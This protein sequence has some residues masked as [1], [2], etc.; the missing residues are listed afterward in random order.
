MIWDPSLENLKCEVKKKK[1]NTYLKVI[2]SIFILLRK[3]KTKYIQWTKTFW[4]FVTFIYNKALL[5]WGREGNE[6]YWGGLNP[7]E[8]IIYGFKALS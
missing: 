7:M 6:T 3:I 1:L 8:I 4:G 5:S 2:G